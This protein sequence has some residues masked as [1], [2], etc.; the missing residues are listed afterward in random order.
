MCLK[1]VILALAGVMAGSTVVAQQSSTNGAG[2]L[3]EIHI[4]KVKPGMTRQYEAGR[5]K[6]MTWHQRQN[7]AW[8]WHTFEILTGEDTGSY[9]VGTFGH[10]WR[11]LDDRTKFEAEDS[12]DAIAHM[13]S[14][15]ESEMQSY[16]L[17]RADLGPAAPPSPQPSPM[18][19]VTHFMLA[20]DGLNDFVESVK[21][22]TEGIKKTNYPMNGANR[23]Y[24]LVNG[25]DSPHFVLVGDRANWAAFEPATKKTLDGMMEEA[26]GKEQGAAALSTLRKTI[27]RVRTEAIRYRPDLSYVPESK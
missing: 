12:A 24:Q 11:D 23:W 21:K 18:A 9:V 8:A 7:D 15:L 13:G 26:F 2:N 22:V 19:S 14:S 5:K 6:H 27:R 1:S 3:V 10:N 17:Y 20:P 25:G 16:Y 4:N